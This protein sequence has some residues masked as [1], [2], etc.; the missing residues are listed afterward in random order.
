M[1]FFCNKG[2]ESYKIQEKRVARGYAWSNFSPSFLSAFY[3]GAVRFSL[4]SSPLLSI[5]QENFRRIIRI[6][7]YP[8]GINC[9][10]LIGHIILSI[11][12]KYFSKE[13]ITR[14]SDLIFIMNETTCV[15]SQVD[16]DLLQIFLVSSFNSSCVSF[17][18]MER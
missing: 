4:P 17:V 8:T 1:N 5:G 9:T 12:R 2:L 6:T 15:R 10:L 11:F 3:F 18:S 7:R 16:N 13:R 14:K